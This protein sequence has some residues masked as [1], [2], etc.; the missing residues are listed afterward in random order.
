[1]IIKKYRPHWY[2]E[3]SVLLRSWHL[4]SADEK[5]DFFSCRR[6]VYV[7]RV[8]RRQSRDRE[9]E[10]LGWPFVQYAHVHDGYLSVFLFHS[11]DDHV[12]DCRFLSNNVLISSHELLQ[13]E[14]HEDVVILDVEL[15]RD[16]VTL[17]ELVREESGDD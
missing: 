1:M 2:T 11:I 14:I 9:R 7:V 8:C 15:T 13:V 3:R 4:A 6:L 17:L 12:G 5:A 16:L 10:G